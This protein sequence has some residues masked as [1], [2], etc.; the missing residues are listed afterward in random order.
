MLSTFFYQTTFTHSGN[1]SANT[2]VAPYDSV[3]FTQLQFHKGILLPL[4]Q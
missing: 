3:M 4:I 1:L 2:T